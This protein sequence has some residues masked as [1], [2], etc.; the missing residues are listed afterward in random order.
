LVLGEQID[1]LIIHLELAS[2]EEWDRVVIQGHQ[3]DD[4]QLVPVIKVNHRI[5]NV[6]LQLMDALLILIL[7]AEE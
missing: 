4:R 1:G 3:C 6:L 7:R 5:L 2:L